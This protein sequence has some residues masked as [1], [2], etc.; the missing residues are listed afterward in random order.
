MLLYLKYS[1][2]V[3]TLFSSSYFEITS[4]EV[5]FITYNSSLY[6]KYYIIIFFNFINC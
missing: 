1:P 6:F 4:K 3:K 5:A 2:K